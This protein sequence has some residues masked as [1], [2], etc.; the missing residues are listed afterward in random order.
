MNEVYC[1]S[2]RALIIPA[3]FCPKCGIDQ[4]RPTETPPKPVY[5]SYRV[6]MK[7]GQEVGPIPLETVYSML[8]QGAIDRDTPIRVDDTSGVIFADELPPIVRGLQPPPR[9]VASPSAYAPPTGVY[10]APTTS[11]SKTPTS[12]PKEARV[13]VIILAVF[14]GCGLLS[15]LPKPD[16]SSYDA[17]IMA[18]T[19]VKRSL[20]SPTTA[21]FPDDSDAPVT[22]V[23]LDGEKWQWRVTGY[24]DS[25]NGFGAMV[26]S[27]YY[28]TLHAKDQRGDSWLCDDARI[29]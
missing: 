15:L 8:D 6:K 18:R 24:V 9:P 17:E 5:S 11:R 21:Q 22:S 1:P 25:Q 12:F 27:K 7:D 19:F 4:R 26:R 10:V 3:A 13:A 16:P 14:G 29:E 20:K 2:C 23:R 28:V